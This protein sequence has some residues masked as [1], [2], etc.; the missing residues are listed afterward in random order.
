MI[1]NLLLTTLL[2]PTLAFSQEIDW[3]KIEHWTGTGDNKAALVVQFSNL[4]EKKAY[5]W[6]FRWNTG[7][8]T[9]TGESMFRAIASGSEDLYLFTQYTGWMGNTVCGIGVNYDG[10]LFSDNLW[11][12]FDSACD[13]PKIS[14][15]YFTPGSMGQTSAPGGDAPELCENAIMEAA[16][17]H[18]LNHPLNAKVYGYAAYDYDHWICNE[19]SSTCLWQAGWY[20]GYWSYWVGT[21]DFSSLGY[22]GMGMSSVQISDGDVNAWKYS[23]ITSSSFD[24][25]PTWHELDY[26][27]SVITGV[28]DVI[29]DADTYADVYNL[30]G[31]Y[32]GRM[33]PS[34][35]QNLAAGLYIVKLK[36]QSYKQLVK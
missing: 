25:D 27:H 22:S 26:T 28:E 15:D 7:D 31:I 12:D 33:M 34:D 30:S 1:K 16:E 20:K 32:V 18:I 24:V 5:V 19:T 6:G 3:N 14:F 9:P 21:A 13:D 36:N 35:V 8:E 29:V 10:M 17:T 2:F 11:F 23:P 4:G